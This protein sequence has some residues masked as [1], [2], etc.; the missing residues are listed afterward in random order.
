MNNPTTWLN[1]IWKSELPSHS[2]LLAAYLRRFMNDDSD[3][4]YPS[5]ARISHETSITKKTVLKYL[6]VLEDKGYLVK[7]SG[8][9]LKSNRYISKLP[10]SYLGS[11]PLT[12][13]S[14]RD[15]PQVVEDVH[16]NKQGLNKQSNKPLVG[17]DFILDQYHGFCTKLKTI[18]KLTDVRK[19]HINA[20][21]DL[22]KTEDE[23]TEYFKTVS[24]SSFLNGLVIGKEFLASFDWLINET[25]MVKVLEGNFV[26]KNI[27][28]A[29]TTKTYRPMPKPG[30]AV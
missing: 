30:E 25:N 2:K 16:P 21:F 13:R 8:N 12:P 6:D 9:S 23:W 28:P 3:I 5:L 24:K 26:D 27:Q 10:E 19:K 22:L 18:K 11:V 20:R 7:Q 1:A 29:Q 14:V 17:Y 15:T 4:A